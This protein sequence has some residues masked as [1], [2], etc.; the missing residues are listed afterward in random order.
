MTFKEQLANDV[1]KVFLCTD[2][3]ADDAVYNSHD[4]T[5][6]DKAIKVILD[7]DVDLGGTAYGVAEMVSIS[8]STADI[9]RPAIYDTILIDGTTYTV[10]QSIDGAVGMIT[11]TC[12]TDRRQTAGAL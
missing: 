12:E 1:D 8:L 2:E 11:V 6:V 10:T 7:L 5:I 4:G 3:F 9:P